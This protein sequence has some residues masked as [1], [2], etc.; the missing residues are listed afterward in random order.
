MFQKIYKYI[1]ERKIT[2]AILI[3]LVVFGV[4]YGYG[5]FQGAKAETSYVLSTVEKGALITSISG[6]GQVTA[7][8][9]V[10][11]KPKIQADIL[12][13]KVKAGDKV[14]AGQLLAELDNKDLLKKVKDAKSSLEQARISLS[15]KLVG[16]TAEEL[17]VSKNSVES[18]KLS[19]DNAVKS[20]DTAK[21][22]AQDNIKQAQLQLNNSEIS[23]ENAQ[24]SYDNSLTSQDLTVDDKSSS[25]SNSYVS[26]KNTLSSS[27]ITMRGSLT[28]A[29]NILGVDHASININLKSVLGVLDFQSLNNAQNAYQNS[30]S[31]LAIFES[32]YNANNAS[33]TET[34]IDDLLKKAMDTYENLQILQHDV[35]NV[36]SK[37]ITSSDISQT[38]L[39]SYKSTISSQESAAIS[40][41]NSIQSS[42][43]SI[44]SAK[45]NIS[46]SDLST[47]GSVASAKNTLQTAKNSLITAQDN[48]EQ[49]KQDNKKN[50]EAA[51]SEIKS[52]KISYDNAVAQHNLKIAKPRPIDIASNQLQVSQAQD[53]YKT[54][55]D[56][57]NNTK[58]VSPIEGIVGKVN[59][60]VGF[61]ASLSTSII[62]IISAKKLPVITVNEVDV[63]R[64]KVGQKVTLTFSAIDGLTLTG[65]VAEIDAIGTIT[66]GVVSYSVKIGMDTD[67]SRIKPEMSVSAT[68]ITDQK[69]DV[70]SVP[71]AAV[72][73]DNSGASYVEVLNGA[74]SPAN[75]GTGVVSSS[76]PEK[77]YVVTGLANDTDTEI[78]QGLSEGDK[79]VTRTVN[80]A[81]AKTTTSAA[82]QGNA[83]RILGGGG[84]GR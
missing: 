31:A 57:L 25:L 38:T 45:L 14:L 70:L 60:E 39:D 10:E 11:I 53:N 78:T 34:A 68:V 43:S 50:I 17:A 27:L 59:Q 35:Y 16:L 76:V 51:E 13:I 29:D 62:T 41:I 77:K 24:R 63:A 64:L 65:Q 71:S 28:A 72:K 22:N 66:Q 46:T 81:T 1:K 26:A 74:T 67:D 18:A 9:Q 79:V 40:G 80:G 52:K 58:I 69:S 30:K 7:D 32:A 82:S 8:N 4:Y 75:S 54:A 47:T 83:F 44:K 15:L 55:L 23:L 33:M 12:S 6:T 5:R 19:Y 21:K 56:D 3:V 73:T 2:F 20:L 42:I 49:A 84:P 37:S 48:L 36:L 61:Q